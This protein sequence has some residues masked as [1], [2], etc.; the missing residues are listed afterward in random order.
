MKVV[1]KQSIQDINAS[2]TVN[3]PTDMDNTFDMKTSS[4]TFVVNPDNTEAYV[5]ESS[6]YTAAGV[7]RVIVIAC[8]GVGL[9]V[10]VIG[11]GFW[12]MIGVETMNVL[13]MMFFCMG[14]MSSLQP[15]MG[16]VT[17]L[18]NTVNG[19]NGLFR[20][21]PTLYNFDEPEL[22][23]MLIQMHI[24][25]RFLENCNIMI[26]GELLVIF[27]G[28]LF[29]LMSRIYD[30]SSNLFVGVAKYIMN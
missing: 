2:I 8:V 9:A 17:E 3:P 1:Y 30:T 16:P 24:G 11:L 4:A 14:M 12:K 6:Q 22:P 18:Y 20:D 7:T 19:Y 15:M 29:F 28:L 23:K 26:A 25:A 21:R 13:Q 27:I 10:L 5:Y